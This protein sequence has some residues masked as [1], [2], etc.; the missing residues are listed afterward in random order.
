MPQIPNSEDAA[1]EAVALRVQKIRPKAMPET[2]TEAEHTALM[3]PRWF[4][5]EGVL[6]GVEQRLNVVFCRSCKETVETPWPERQHVRMWPLAV[7][8]EKDPLRAVGDL[9]NCL[10]YHCGFEMHV[11]IKPQR[12][13]H[14]FDA[15]R[16]MG[17]AAAFGQM[18]GAVPNNIGQ[19][20]APPQPTPIQ[21]LQNTYAEMIR[22]GI[23]PN[24][25][26][27]ME[28]RIE[29]MYKRQMELANSPPLDASKLFP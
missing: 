7:T 22:R 4:I 16:Q 12:Q 23:A 15:A 6:L 25:L 13:Q 11:N 17:K 21:Q 10:C 3:A 1:R 27:Q 5:T 9:A 8:Y 19:Q 28:E 14:G 29:E 24:H 18:Y 2:M 26:K 20:L